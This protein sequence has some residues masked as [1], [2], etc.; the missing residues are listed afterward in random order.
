M[1]DYAIKPTMMPT[2]MGPRF[3]LLGSQV[4]SNALINQATVNM[5][6]ISKAA[7]AFLKMKEGGNG[8][9]HVKF[10]QDTSILWAPKAVISRSGLEL[11]EISVLE[12]IESACFYYIAPFIAGSL[13]SPLFKKATPKHAKATMAAISQKLPEKASMALLRNTVPAKLGLAVASVGIATA[14]EYG[15]NF[16]KN[17]L[18]EWKFK[19]NDFSSIIGFTDKTVSKKEGESDVV[20]KAKRRMLQSALVA[21]GILAGS[22]AFTRYGS[23]LNNAQLKGLAK[24]ANW[25][26]FGFSNVQASPSWANTLKS[27]SNKIIRTT[28]KIQP[29]VSKT[30]Y[31]IAQNQL[32]VLMPFAILSYWDAARDKLERIEAGCRSLVTGSYIAY[33]QPWL[34]EN[35]SRLYGQHY[36]HLNIMKG[37]DFSKVKT[38][39]EIQA[40][41]VKEATE[42]MT[43]AGQRLSPQALKKKTV[44]LLRPKFVA[45]AEL[46]FI[47]FLFGILGVGLFTALM[48]QMWTSYRFNK[49]LEEV[50]QTG[51]VPKQATI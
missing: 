19:K 25:F 8:N 17:I 42:A 27:L 18:T 3:G 44:E 41:A 33:I 51:L 26:D 24:W 1:N 35:F 49:A 38:L 28:Y 15:L 6:G 47:P 46:F 12:F 45:K 14:L 34:E 4:A 13:L 36:R 5:G 10:V 7:A 11:F 29:N 39:A 2:R 20:K 31:D 50:K 16:G 32:K 9:S 30:K 22:L 48:N 37:K 40:D 43:K 21:G 23:G